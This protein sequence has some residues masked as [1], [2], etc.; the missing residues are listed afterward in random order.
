M[1]VLDRNCMD[2]EDVRHMADA[3]Q[4]RLGVRLIDKQEIT[5]QCRVCME[6]WS[7]QLDSNGKLPFDYWVCPANCNR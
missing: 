6:T 2:K 4:A 1:K 7:P 5:L 3:E